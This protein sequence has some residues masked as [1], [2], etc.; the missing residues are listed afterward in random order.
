MKMCLFSH[1]DVR[2]NV[3]KILSYLKIEHC[4][5]SSTWWY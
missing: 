4:V 1:E 3:D 5:E 2:R